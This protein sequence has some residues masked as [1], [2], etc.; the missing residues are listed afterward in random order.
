MKQNTDPFLSLHSLDQLKDI[1]ARSNDKVQVLFK[2]S[3]RCGTSTFAKKILMD[4]ITDELK[5][6]YDIYYLDL[7]QHRDISNAIATAY[8][9]EHESPQLLFISKGKCVYHA[10][11]D[12]VSLKQAMKVL[13]N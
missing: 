8:G 11:H 9:V 3:T 2:H 5:S 13:E 4:E 6:R 1:H 7:L 12:D 10:S